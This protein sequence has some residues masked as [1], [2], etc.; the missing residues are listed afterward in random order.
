MKVKTHLKAGPGGYI[1]DNGY[2][3]CQRGG[4]ISSNSIG[5]AGEVVNE[6]DQLLKGVKYLVEAGDE[7]LLKAIHG[8]KRA[9]A[10]KAAANATKAT[11]AC[12]WSEETRKLILRLKTVALLANQGS[13]PPTGSRHEQPEARSPGLLEGAT[14]GDPLGAGEGQAR[15]RRR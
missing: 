2:T 14:P 11:S 10:K 7:E 15:Y 13:D 1:D 9:A 12:S 4:T 5:Q 8:A 3:L 6:L